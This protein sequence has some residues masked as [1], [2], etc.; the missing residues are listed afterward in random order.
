MINVEDA[1]T[2]RLNTPI[3]RQPKADILDLDISED[4]DDGQPLSR[5][6]EDSLKAADGPP[7]HPSPRLDASDRDHSTPIASN[8]VEEQDHPPL[9]TPIASSTATR[10]HSR[11]APRPKVQIQYFIITACAPRLSYTLWLEG[12]LRHKT[13]GEIF[14]DVATYTSARRVEKIVFELTTS[15]A[16][17]RYLIRRNDEDVFEDM[18]REFNER[19][20]VDRKRG[21]TKF[22]IWLEPDPTG[23]GSTD[24]EGVE[25]SE[26]EDDIV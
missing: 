10:E 3:S 1:F 20:R 21:I 18:R 11:N 13:L 9:P 5:P 2:S 19:L 25:G 24:V 17:I 23:Q 8:I 26:S 4:S 14:D 16:R 7:Y 22:K 6:N 12:T 15:R